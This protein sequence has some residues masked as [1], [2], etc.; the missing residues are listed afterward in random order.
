MQANLTD[1]QLLSESAEARAARK[2]AAI[3]QMCD[4]LFNLEPDMLGYT[5]E[6]KRMTYIQLSELLHKCLGMDETAVNDNFVAIQET[7]WVMLI[8]KRDKCHKDPQ[9]LYFHQTFLNIISYLRVKEVINAKVTKL[10]NIL[11]PKVDKALA[12]NLDRPIPD[13]AFPAG[14]AEMIDFYINSL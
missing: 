11:C 1:E 4:K 14:T 12:K 3:N 8:D 10:F 2:K 5:Q 7:I 9:D 13:T 6:Q